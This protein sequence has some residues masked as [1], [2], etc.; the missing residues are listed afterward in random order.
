MF[1]SDEL[2]ALATKEIDATEP[3]IRERVVDLMQL[4]IRD[5]G[6]DGDSDRQLL[7]DGQRANNLWNGLIDRLLRERHPFRLVLKK[8]GIAIL[9]AHRSGI[10]VRTI[11]ADSLPE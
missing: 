8:D 11:R 3:A 6:K 5:I 4:A 7:A 1:L 9:L 10:D 2:Y